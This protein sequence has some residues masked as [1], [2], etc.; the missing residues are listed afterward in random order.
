LNRPPRT[1]RTPRPIPRPGAVVTISE[2]DSRRP[3]GLRNLSIEK[4]RVPIRPPEL[5]SVHA[6]TGNYPRKT[7]IRTGD[8]RSYEGVPLLQTPVRV[9]EREV[10]REGDKINNFTDT[11]RLVDSWARESYSAREVLDF[12]KRGGFGELKG[13]IAGRPSGIL[14]DGRE[15]PREARMKVYDGVAAWYLSSPSRATSRRASGARRA[16]A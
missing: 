8:L 14:G 15:V 9:S 2:V 1:P 10:E 12:K 6:V 5:T 13:P 4:R 3:A 7:T 16:P 11:E